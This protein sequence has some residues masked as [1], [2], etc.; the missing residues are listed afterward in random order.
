MRHRCCGLGR[1]QVFRA[2]L[3]FAL[4]GLLPGAP[5]LF[6][7]EPFGELIDVRSGFTRV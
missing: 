6:G 3:I 5:P 7:Q 4:V 2:T 1:M